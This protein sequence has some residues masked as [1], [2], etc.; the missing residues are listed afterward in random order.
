MPALFVQPLGR[1]GPARGGTMSNLLRILL[2]VLLPPVG[3]FFT[4]GL[5]GQFWL[6]I[7][8]TICG[9]IPGIVHAVWI[10]ARRT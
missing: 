3:V 6:N 1:A 8:L 10:I 5:G 9:Y 4:V 7:L 2:A